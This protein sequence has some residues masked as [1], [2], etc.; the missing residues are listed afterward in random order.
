[1]EEESMTALAQALTRM[2]GRNV[3]VEALKVVA[4]FCCT[5]LFITLVMLSYGLDVTPGAF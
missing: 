2:S 1:M 3:D 5:G 4:V